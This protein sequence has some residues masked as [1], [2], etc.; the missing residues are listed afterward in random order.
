[1]NII[2][3]MLQLERAGA[4]AGKLL[5]A[6]ELEL[7]RAESSAANEDDRIRFQED[8]KLLELRRSEFFGDDA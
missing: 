5:D 6:A 3:T 4:D 8:L 7:Q 2:P 1:M